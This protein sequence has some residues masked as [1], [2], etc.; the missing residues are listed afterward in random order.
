MEIGITHAQPQRTYLMLNTQMLTSM[1]SCICLF[2]Q[3]YIHRHSMLRL[4][5]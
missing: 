1:C 2:L 4:Q 3:F 5:T